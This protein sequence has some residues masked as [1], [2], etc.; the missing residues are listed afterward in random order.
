M[1]DNNLKRLKK[2]KKVVDVNILK[3]INEKETLISRDR[4]DDDSIEELERSFPDEIQKREESLKIH[5]PE[6]DLKFFK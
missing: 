4:Y 6:N 3:V 5:R 2:W 1:V